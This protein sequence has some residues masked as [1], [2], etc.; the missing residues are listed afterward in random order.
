MANIKDIETSIKQNLIDAGCD[1]ETIACCMH[2]FQ[3]GSST[4]M[5]PTL[6]H[7]RTTLLHHIR[8]KQKQLDCLD[9]LIYQIHK[10][11]I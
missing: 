5:L 2:S 8:F 11:Q 3:K 1:E 7:Y 9:Y 6:S 4:H 10:H